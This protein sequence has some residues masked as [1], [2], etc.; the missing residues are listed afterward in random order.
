M[1]RIMGTGGLLKFVPQ[2]MLDDMIEQLRACLKARQ[3]ASLGPHGADNMRTYW[4][5]LGV[6]TREMSNIGATPNVQFLLETL[7]DLMY[8][9][10]F[11][12][13]LVSHVACI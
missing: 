8:S 6:M 4:N 10:R 11:C 13:D 2:L 7:I 9:T 12:V 5:F 1:L 3:K